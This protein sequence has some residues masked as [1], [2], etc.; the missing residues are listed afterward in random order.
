MASFEDNQDGQFAVGRVP[1][2]FYV[3]RRFDKDAPDDPSQ[4]FAYQVFDSDGE[5]RFESDRGWD[6]TLRETPTRQ[7]VK[8]IFFEEDRSLVSLAFQRFRYDGQPLADKKTLIL[9]EA[10]IGILLDFVAKIRVADLYGVDAVRFSVDASSQLLE[11]RRL[12][13]ELLRERRDDVEEFLRSD[14]TAPEVTALARRR[15]ALRTFREMLKQD[16]TEPKWQAF[17]ESEPWLL[18]FGGAPQFL[19]AVGQKLEQVVKGFDLTSAGK[20]TDALL[21]TAGQLSA[22]TFVEIKRPDTPL[23]QT[24]DYRPDVWAVSSEVA[25]GVAQ[26]HATVDAARRTIGDRLHMRDD[27]G[28]D[29]GNAIELCRPRTVLVTGQLSQLFNEDGM[30]HRQRFRAFESFRRSLRDPEVITFDELLQRAEAVIA[31]DERT[32]GPGHD[33]SGR[34]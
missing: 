7:Q 24:S 21:R 15:T 16:L 19:H 11:G 6:V 18:G 27:E 5:V 2:R 20:R 34:G 26:L 29:S 10:E 33:D 25:G 23:L 12:P 13:A 22:L 30:P 3:S 4:R 8:A 14:V 32:R 31:L 28:Y 1:G 17:L 9:N